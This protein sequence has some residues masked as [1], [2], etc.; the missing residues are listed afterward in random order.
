MYHSNNFNGKY[1]AIVGPKLVRTT[2][3]ETGSLD[4]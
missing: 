1:W 4:N 2:R 3:K